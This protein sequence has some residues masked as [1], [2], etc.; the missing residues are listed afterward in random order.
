MAVIL[1]MQLN[2][3]LYVRDPQATELGKRIIKNS[4]ELIDTLGFESFTFKKL[5]ERIESTEASVYRYFENKHN[6]L[7][8]LVSWYWE[9]LKYR[10]EVRITNL[11][12]PQDILRTSLA[13]IVEAS[14]DD[15]Q[16]DFVDESL[17]HSIVVLESPKAHHLKDVDSRN[18]E[19]FYINFKSLVMLIAGQIQ[20]MSPEYP[21]AN[22]LATTLLEMAHNQ[23]FYARHLP[24]LTS[25][26]PEL[27]HLKDMLEH[28]TFGQL[29]SPK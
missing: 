23:L 14:L 10:I 11:Q 22:T 17:L 29:S 7:I 20:A 19:G 1:Q 15:P 12:S 3:K 2:D 25:I 18:R 24:T 6:L 16:T 8:Y 13:V 9:A 26:K 27:A 28:F 5:A 21:Y 4:I